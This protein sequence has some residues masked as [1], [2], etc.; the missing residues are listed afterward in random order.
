M[1][2]AR[3]CS[4]VKIVVS[5]SRIIGLVS[6]AAVSLSMVS[7]SS[8]PVASSSR[9]IWKPSLASSRTRCDCSVFLR[10]VRDLL[11]RGNFGDDPLLQQQADFVDHHQLAGIGNR[12][13]QLAVRRFFQRHKVVAE[14]QLRGK[15][16]EQL[17]MKLEVGEIDKLAAIAPRHVLR[18]L[19]VGDRISRRHHLPAVLAV[20][21][22]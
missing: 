18:A 3:R 6:P 11:Q 13:G 7:V 17:M 5:T 4:A 1:S 12:N 22:K 19:Q 2:E 21:K 15:L 14:H 10:I 16:L 8:A 9:M 20:Y